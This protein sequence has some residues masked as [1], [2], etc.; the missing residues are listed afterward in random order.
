MLNKIWIIFQDI[1]I[2]FNRRNHRK[3]SLLWRLQ[4]FRFHSSG[5]RGMVWLYFAVSLYL[6]KFVFINKLIDNYLL[7]KFKVIN[8][9]NLTFLIFEKGKHHET[10]KI[11]KAFVTVYWPKVGLWPISLLR[12]FCTKMSSFL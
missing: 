11:H 8:K 6:G 3:M 2:C 12:N 1:Q 7:F 10:V 4:R 5:Y 9:N